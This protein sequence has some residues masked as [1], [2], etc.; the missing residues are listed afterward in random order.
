MTETKQSLID[1]L[2]PTAVLM[3]M[4]K[5]ATLS[6]VSA[7]TAKSLI[8]MDRFPFRIG[9][10]SR[11]SEDDR[12]L[13]VKWRMRTPLSEPNNDV[14]LVNTTKHMQLSKEH[15]LIDKTEQGYVIQDRHSTLGTKVN[16]NEIG[17]SKKPDAHLLQDGDIVKI[18]DEQSKLEFQFLI[19]K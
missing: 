12:G 17:L 15:F 1:S 7:N 19:L 11:I 4:T 9:R 6:I 10:E 18:G 14:Y 8:P 3:P 13:M 5:E 2:I 16:S